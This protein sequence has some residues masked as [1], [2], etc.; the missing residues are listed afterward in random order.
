M[1]AD[2]VEGVEEGSSGLLAGFH[3]GLVVGVDVDQRGV[4]RDGALEEGDEQAEL[5]GRDFGDGDR[6]RLAAGFVERLA[7]A[8]EEALEEIAGG[9]AGFDFDAVAG[10]GLC[11]LR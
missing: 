2:R 7:G 8:A 5:E 6:E 10:R 9:D 1:A 4:E 11:A 3:A